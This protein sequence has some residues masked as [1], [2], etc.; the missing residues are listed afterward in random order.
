M[1]NY[2]A[3][4]RRR[5]DTEWERVEMIDVGREYV[6]GFHDGK[7]YQEDMCE[8]RPEGAEEYKLD[9]VINQLTDGL[10]KLNTLLKDTEF[11]AVKT[12]KKIDTATTD[13]WHLDPKGPMKASFD[14][15]NEIIDYL[16]EK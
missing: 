1:S 10:E 3:W 13:H 11:P 8:I 9:K 4:G 5:G 12:I 6:V 14:K 7:V 15:I 16:N 2:Y